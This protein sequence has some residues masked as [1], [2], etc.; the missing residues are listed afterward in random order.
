MTELKTLKDIEDEFWSDDVET[1]IDAFP[2]IRKEA[3]KWIKDCD[4]S[5][6]FHP[7][8]LFACTRCHDF[9]KFFNITEAELTEEEKGEKGEMKVEVKR[10]REEIAQIIMKN[11]ELLKLNN[12]IAYDLADCILLYFIE[13]K[14]GEKGK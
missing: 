2:K 7:E 13:K 9:I 12:K 10:D 5:K 6:H 11:I 14:Q 1:S 3:I 8:G 4:C